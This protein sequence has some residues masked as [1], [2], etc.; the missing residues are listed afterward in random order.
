MSRAN[1]NG[2]LRAWLPLILTV[3]LLLGTGYAGYV[4][5]QAKA[6]ETERRV[7]RL[8]VKMDDV[9]EDTAWLCGRLGRNPDE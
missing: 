9:K 5:T 4:K 6:W 8:E 1:V 3:V 2:W 7:D